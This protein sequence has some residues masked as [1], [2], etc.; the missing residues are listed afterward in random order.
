M[1]LQ[2]F[3]KQVRYEV[4]Y[5]HANKHQSFPQFDFRNLGIT[6]S[7]KVILLFMGMVKHFQST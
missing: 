6:V 3:I 1:S 7:H 4:D 2:D 5:L